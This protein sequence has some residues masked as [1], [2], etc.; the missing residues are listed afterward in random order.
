MTTHKFFPLLLGTSICLSP[1]GVKA[2][3]PAQ[4]DQAIE[5]VGEPFDG[6]TLATQYDKAVFT[7]GEPIKVSFRLKNLRTTQEAFLRTIDRQ[8]FNLKVTT[9][10]EKPVARTEYGRTEINTK[11]AT[12]ARLKQGDE[13]TG[14]LNVN[15][16]YD[17]T[18]AGKYNITVSTRA[19]GS[20][21]YVYSK[22]TTITVAFTSF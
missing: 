5:Q 11:S 8:D 13:L 14:M 15:R 21:T 10:D 7:D 6:F 18:K 17:M 22:T 19:P 1:I 20:G 9:A 2:Q 16:I 4:T 3:Q 12:T